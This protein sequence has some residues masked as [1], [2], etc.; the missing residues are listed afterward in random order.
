M[1]IRR[2]PLGAEIRKVEYF[3]LLNKDIHLLGLSYQSIT[4]E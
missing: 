3:P 2:S 4:S 1:T